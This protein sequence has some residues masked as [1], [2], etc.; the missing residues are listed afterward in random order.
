MTV[1]TGIPVWCVV[2]LNL[3][4]EIGAGIAVSGVA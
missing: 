3:G 2:R 1:L 4:A